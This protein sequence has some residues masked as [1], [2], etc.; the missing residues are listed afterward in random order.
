[1]K[2]AIASAAVKSRFDFFAE[3][4]TETPAAQPLLYKFIHVTVSESNSIPLLTVETVKLDLTEVTAAQWF[5]AFSSNNSLA[6]ETR[7]DH[8]FVITVT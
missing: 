5:L 8:S 6:H 4:Y 7:C 1:M 3:P 2:F